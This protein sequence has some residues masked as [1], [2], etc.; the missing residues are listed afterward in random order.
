MVDK[1]QYI[2]D[3]EKR[4]EEQEEAF[5]KE[6]YELEN[7]YIRDFTRVPLKFLCGYQ[8][9]LC[10]NSKACA[11]RYDDNINSSQIGLSVQYDT[12]LPRHFINVKRC[13]NNVYRLI[14]NN[15]ESYDFNIIPDPGLVWRSIV[16]HIRTLYT[17]I[18]KCSN[19]IAHDTQRGAGN[20]IWCSIKWQRYFEELVGR[21][22][23]QYDTTSRSI[24]DI[25]V[26]YK[27]Q[28]ENDAGLIFCPLLK[29]KDSPIEDTTIGA[30][31][32]IGDWTSY[33]KVIRIV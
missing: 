12:P 19:K 33:Y 9:F 15:C 18:L 10:K 22:T 28:K 20:F 16:E 14:M 29:E 1:D 8:P 27:G 23:I 17:S 5:Q 32:Q 7:D 2:L 26:G 30:I 13:E 4:L 11:L 31:S 25:I 21:F 24:R 3:L 6:L